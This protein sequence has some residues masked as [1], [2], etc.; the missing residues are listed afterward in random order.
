MEN[1]KAKKKKNGRGGKKMKNE[2]IRKAGKI[3]KHLEEKKKKK[4]Q[5]E[6]DRVSV[7]ER[8]CEKRKAQE[9]PTH[10]EWGTINKDGIA[11]A[12]WREPDETSPGGSRLDSLHT[13]GERPASVRCRREQRGCGCKQAL[14]RLGR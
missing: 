11:S 13:P 6:R 7:R 4:K 8:V 10:E 1:G 2:K 5:P 9:E 3:M 12:H 14:S